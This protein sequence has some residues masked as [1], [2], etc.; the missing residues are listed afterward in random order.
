MIPR[1]I[2]ALPSVR[3]SLVS[4]R[5]GLLG[6]LLDER[7]RWALWLPVMF[8]LGIAVY[9]G[10]D[11]EPPLWLGLTG[12]ATAAALGL[13]LHRRRRD[14]TGVGVAAVVALAVVAAGFTAAQWRTASVAAPVLA[15]RI[16][17]TAVT[18]RVHEIETFPKDSRVTFERVRIVGIGAELTPDRVRLRLRGEQPEIRPGDWLRIRAILTPP[19]PPSAPGA[20]DFQRQSYFKR[21]GAVG[22]GLGAVEVLADRGADGDGLAFFGIGVE[23]L[24][25]AVTRRIIAGLPGREGAVAAALMTGDRSAIPD[26]LMDAMRN[27]GLAHL[28]AISGLHIGLVAGILLIGLRAMMA[29]IPPLALNFHIKKIAAAFSIGGAFSYAL[30][31]GATIPTQRAFVMVGLM[32]VAVLVD[33]RALSVRL[34][35]WAAMIVLLVQ[36]ESLL[37]ASFQM[38]FGA[39]ITLIAA[40]EVLSHRDRFANYDSGVLPPW[41]RKAGLYITG[42]ATT[43]MIAG[44]ATAPFA[45]YHFNRFA[46]YGL[47]ANIVAVPVTALW[48]MPW[49]VVAFLLMPVGLEALA[50]APMGW[51]LTEVIAVAET[52]ASWPGAVTRVPSMPTYGLAAIALGGL[53]LALWRRR[54]RLLGIGG[55]A[56]GF[57]ALALVRPPDVLIDGQARLLAVRTADGGMTVSSLGRARF[58]RETWLRRVGQEE[59]EGAWPT[60]G[61]SADKRLSCDIEGCLY[62]VGGKV[63]ALVYED[64]GL[65]EDCWVAD[66]IIALNPVR[67]TCPAARV[68]DR[69]DLWRDGAHALWL[70]RGRLRVETVNGARGDRPW[71]PRPQP[72]AAKSRRDGR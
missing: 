58:E 25:H 46:D 8:G 71:V 52:V 10:L 18:G 59:A 31:A 68:I 34:I 5:S 72:R 16:G 23:R 19:P 29:L 6:R 37:G 27:S 32:L 26:P 36:P 12:M 15:K 28:L 22:F 45:L 67:R 13:A 42:V 21:L 66:V 38:S 14:A 33:R 53:W 3:Q 56:A 4:L 47:A 7:D 61:L 11:F 1:L 24:R 48:V 65:A 17:P 57:A 50:L 60:S 43:T 55:I 39:V 51:G 35:A 63:V 54:W 70:E 30:I 62:R 41:L 69:F 44:A 64:S 40:Y 2:P 9:F 20:F 49:A